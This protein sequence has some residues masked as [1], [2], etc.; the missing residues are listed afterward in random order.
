MIQELIIWTFFADLSIEIKLIL[1]IWMIN[2]I[3]YKHDSFFMNI[4]YESRIW[5]EID[6][7]DSCLMNIDYDMRVWFM[8]WDDLYSMNIS[9]LEIE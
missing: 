1:K 2:W 7:Y 4:N 8:I 6:E 5:F 9:Y 3:F